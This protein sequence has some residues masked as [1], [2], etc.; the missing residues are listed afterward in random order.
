MGGAL[1]IHIGSIRRIVGGN[2]EN[3]FPVY[4]TCLLPEIVASSW[5]SG[6]DKTADVIVNVSGRPAEEVVR[7]LQH[8]MAVMRRRWRH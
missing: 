6:G 1:G 3:T 2:I 8:M 5:L 7:D 4:I